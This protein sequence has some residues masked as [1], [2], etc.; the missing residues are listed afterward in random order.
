MFAG[1]NAGYAAAYSAKQLGIP[2]TIVIPGS[3][4]EFVADQ[5]RDIK[6]HV[7]RH[8]QVSSNNVFQQPQVGSTPEF[9]GDQMKDIKA[10]VIR[11]GQVS[12]NHS[13]TREYP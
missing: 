13:D 5:M 12:S 4:P 3:T 1:G 11:H 7:I 10:H 8:G 9:V 2:A 6:A